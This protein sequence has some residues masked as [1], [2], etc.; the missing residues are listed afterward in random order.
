MN[1]DPYAVNWVS[2]HGDRRSGRLP[3]NYK[4]GVGV[5]IPNE[6]LDKAVERLG[7]NRR[8]LEVVKA[9][10]FRAGSLVVATEIPAPLTDNS[11]ARLAVEGCT[12]VIMKVGKDPLT[13]AAGAMVPETGEFMSTE[14]LPVVTQAMDLQYARDMYLQGVPIL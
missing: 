3:A 7:A 8:H 9:V 4:S 6:P 12:T 11:P 13:V 10:A 1:T 5:E 2:R 14:Q